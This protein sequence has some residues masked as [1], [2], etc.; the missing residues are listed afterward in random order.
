MQ[1]I[2]NSSFS[3]IS[4]KYI[5]QHFLNTAGWFSGS[6]STVPHFNFTYLEKKGKNIQ[7]ISNT[8]YSINLNND[9]FKFLLEKL[10]CSDTQNPDDEPEPLLE[11]A[12][13]LQIHQY[14]QDIISFCI[15]HKMA[16]ISKMP[17]P[18]GLPFAFIIS[19]D[20]DL[21]RKYGIRSLFKDICTAKFSEF[22][23][24]YKQS[25]YQN[26]I[27]WNFNKLLAFYR[28]MQLRSSFFFIAR[29]WENLN[30]RYRIESRK[31]RKLLEDLLRDQHEI[32][33]HSSRYTFDHPIRIGKEK[34]K[35]QTISGAELKGVR[36]HYLRLTFPQGWQNFRNHGFEYDSSGGY[37][38]SMG[39]RAG[40]SFPFKTYDIQGNEILNMYEI[41]FSVMDYPWEEMI[42]KSSENSDLFIEFADQVMGMSGLL[43]ILWHPHNL[44]EPDF[45]PLWKK[46]FSWLDSKKFYNDTLKNM[47]K[48]WKK[49][50]EVKLNKLSTG[51]NSFDFDIES[52]NPLKDL[53]LRIISPLPLQTTDML[54]KSIPESQFQ[55]EFRLPPLTPGI[56]E[57]RLPFLN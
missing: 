4:Q 32:G 25:V 52:A 39:F 42:S 51:Q 40:T 12:V 1:V 45:I 8:E 11:P 27:Y 35:L 6:T 21:I 34:E 29:P 20:I 36:Q 37:N 46:I 41:P 57:F 43:H 33:L 31:M 49:R 30:Y 10:A 5:Y 3:S 53:C 54:I 17:W 38:D 14:Q 50:A 47:V 2:L 18:K 48:W 22:T 7:Q 19:H 23:N 24:H 26:N 44:A 55:Y 9:A 16:F 28:D 56:H 15:Q 13:D